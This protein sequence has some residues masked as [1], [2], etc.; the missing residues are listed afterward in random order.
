VTAASACP[1]CLRRSWL[2]ARLGAWIQNVVDDRDGHRTPELLRLSNEDLVEAVAA[3]QADEIL[4][5]NWS[6]SEQEMRASL[7]N[8]DC[9]ACCRHDQNF[10]EG[11]ADGADAPI[12]LIGRGGGIR[13]GS[14]DLGNSVTVVGARKATGYG[15][16]VASSLGRDIAAAGLNVISGMALGIDGAV[17]RGALERGPTVAVLGCG[18]DRPYPATHTRLYRQIL[19]RGLIISEQPP[20]ADAWR[21]SFPARNRIM[22]ALSGMTVVVEA[23]WRSGSLITAEMA[24]DAGRD[25]GAVPGP[26]TAGAAAGTNE[27]ISSGAALIR[28][29]QDVLDR[30]LGAGAGQ[31]LFGPEI[32]R[33]EVEV[34]EAVEAGC[35]TVDEVAERVGQH[36]GAVA[37]ILARLE[38]RGYLRGSA[39]GTWSRTSLAAYP[40]TG[41][42]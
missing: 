14:I 33:S 30:M 28:G 39:V 37:L 34:M 2:I 16:E 29:G 13:L 25:V 31:P 12:A 38:V 36:S 41:E 32:D 9:W 3:K 17:H 18:A 1:E 21:W 22:A 15:L 8:A 5:W 26:V 20:G 11:F 6:L 10:P 23:A 4:C 27:L 19:D 24:Y 35:V 42:D 40:S 7:E